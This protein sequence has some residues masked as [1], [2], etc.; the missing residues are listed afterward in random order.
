[1]ECWYCK[2]IGRLRRR[3]EESLSLQGTQGARTVLSS[4]SKHRAYSKYEQEFNCT[5]G[6]HPRRE[7]EHHEAAATASSVLSGFLGS[8][9]AE[10]MSKPVPSENLH[11]S[12]EMR[13][14]RQ[15]RAE[16]LSTLPPRGHGAA[17]D[18]SRTREGWASCS[19]EER[20]P[21]LAAHWGVSSFL[22]WRAENRGSPPPSA[23]DT[24]AVVYLGMDPH[25]KTH[26]GHNAANTL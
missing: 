15:T 7:K 8:E 3:P 13:R 11:S 26:T 16:V 25:L 14:W 5:G 1:M 6:S 10:D 20:L 22:G 9:K 23:F 18:R 19:E 4:C 2:W 21:L 24:E 17:G 12:G